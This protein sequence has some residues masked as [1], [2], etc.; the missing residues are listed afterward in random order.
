M[1]YRRLSEPE[2]ER[3]V[4][5]FTA[6]H[7]WRAYVAFARDVYGPAAERIDVETSAE[8]NGEHSSMMVESVEVYC[9]GGKTLEPDLSTDWWQTQLEQITASQATTN[10][11]DFDVDVN[12]FEELIS[13]RRYNL[14]VVIG[15]YYTFFV[16]QPPARN[17]RLLYVDE[18]PV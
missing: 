18:E 11:E 2:L 15:G 6:F 14:P 4:R 1:P 9:A 13:E 16:S 12:L 3:F 8:Y 5:D 7:E 10:P 17:H